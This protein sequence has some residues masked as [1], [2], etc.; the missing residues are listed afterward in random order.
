MRGPCILA[1]AVSFVGVPSALYNNV[2]SRVPSASAAQ[3]QKAVS[4]LPADIV[5]AWEKAGAWAVWMSPNDGGLAFRIAADGKQEEV[6]GFAF[7]EWKPGVVGRL[8]QPGRGFGLSLNSSGVRDTELKELAG[9]S[10]VRLLS[11]Y[12]TDVTDAGLKEIAGLTS[13]QSLDLGHTEVTD[14]GLKELAG[15][16][17]LQWLGLIRTRVTDVGLKELAGLK[18]LKRST[19]RP[20]ACRTTG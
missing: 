14:P 15:L 18:S 20:R 10:S 6:P 7:L 1:L 4:P 3:E 9:L 16:K 8:P 12:R 13:L 2:Q 19:S 11:L 5:A 17:S